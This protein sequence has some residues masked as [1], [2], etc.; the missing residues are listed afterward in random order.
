MWLIAL[1]LNVAS[2]E[3]WLLISFIEAPWYCL[4]CYVQKITTTT[5]V[6]FGIY[7]HYTV[8]FA[9]VSYQ[10]CS[11]LNYLKIHLRTY[12]RCYCQLTYDYSVI[13][14]MFY[15]KLS[16]NFTFLT[17]IESVHLWYFWAQQSSSIQ[18]NPLSS[19]FDH[20]QQV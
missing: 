15:F 14:N 16:P 9:T 19:I 6:L 18:R 5:K 12:I 10:Y 3:F 17:N 8:I 1:D 20:Q 11:Y 2:S 13:F 4:F 7:F